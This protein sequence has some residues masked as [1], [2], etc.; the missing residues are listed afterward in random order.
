VKLAPGDAGELGIT[1]KEV[2]IGSVD[3]S[4]VAQHRCAHALRAGMV[5][6]GVNG[7][8]A[9]QLPFQYLSTLLHGGHS[10][11]GLVLRLQAP[12]Q[13]AAAPRSQQ[14]TTIGEAVTKATAHCSAR[15]L[16]LGCEPSSSPSSPS[17]SPAAATD[18]A[19]AAHG[20]ARQ[21]MSEGP[22]PDFGPGPGPV[23]CDD[24]SDDDEAQ[25]LFY[26]KLGA[27]DTGNLGI[28]LRPVSIESVNPTGLAQYR[29]NVVRVWLSF[30]SGFCGGAAAGCAV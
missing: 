30:S 7:V 10:T 23:Q 12:E 16:S 15:Q 9:D 11:Q 29:S 4:G 6:R 21:P 19:S 27:T 24:S 1:F 17:S 5:L 14:Y 3:S 13:A 18:A 26:V 8:E 28:T 25:G 2:S 22:T 20:L